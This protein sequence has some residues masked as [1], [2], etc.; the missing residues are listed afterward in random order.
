MTYLELLNQI[1][2][3]NSIEEFAKINKL[4]IISSNDGRHII[5]YDKNMCNT[6][7]TYIAHYCRGLTLAGDKG[8]YY[9]VAKPFNRF[10]N[11]EELENNTEPTQYLNKY[12]KF[13]LFKPYQIFKKYDGSIIIMYWYDNKIRIN[14]RGGFGQSELSTSN[15]KSWEQSVLDCIDSQSLA[16]YKEQLQK[17]VT[18]LFEYCSP[19]NQ[20]VERY[21]KAQLIQ[22]GAIVTATGEE[23]ELPKGIHYP[24]MELEKLNP[25]EEG[26]VLTQWD[27]SQNIY[28][29]A[30]VKQASYLK[31]AYQLDKVFNT[32]AKKWENIIFKNEESEV[33]SYFP[34]MKKELD[35]MALIYKNLLRVVPAQVKEF[36]HLQGGDLALA[37]KDIEWK[38]IFFSLRK[39]SSVTEAIQSYILKNK[40]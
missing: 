36:G 16:H 18:L 32:R 29:R 12:D 14:T 22:L 10:F 23:L 6:P 8:N 7:D 37:V 20:V 5:N 31:L 33:G 2:Q 1:N 17:G 4:K 34:N 11:L 30:K 35:E 9:P 27:K 25:T 38:F 15:G 3:A 26:Y 13:D 21:E 19:N 39:F 24:K 28:L 40:M